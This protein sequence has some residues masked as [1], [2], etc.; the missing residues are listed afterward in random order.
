MRG[1]HWNKWEQSHP[2]TATQRWTLTFLK[3]KVYQSC[4][5]SNNCMSIRN[6]GAHPSVVNRYHCIV[7]AY[8][9]VIQFIFTSKNWHIL[10]T[11]LAK[12]PFQQ[13]YNTMF[14]V[15]IIVWS[16]PLYFVCFFIIYC[17]FGTN[18]VV[19]SEMQKIPGYSVLVQTSHIWHSHVIEWIVLH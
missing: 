16:M 12:L 9:W 19:V 3:I 14:M 8:I 18:F 15:L 6:W 4:I 11:C 17:C 2:P 7:W 1:C 13:Q 5:P 10:I